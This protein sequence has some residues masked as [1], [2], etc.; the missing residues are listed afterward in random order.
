MEETAHVMAKINHLNLRKTDGFMLA[1]IEKRTDLRG[2]PF[3]M[4]DECRTREAQA[5]M[6]AQ[7]AE[8][9]SRTVAQA[10]VNGNGGTGNIDQMWASFMSGQS[11]LSKV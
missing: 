5:K 9:F 7:V 4:G 3:L 8:T 2:L 10:K 6:F 11:Q 1:M